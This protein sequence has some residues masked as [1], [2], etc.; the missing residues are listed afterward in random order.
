MTTYSDVKLF[1]FLKTLILY[2]IYISYSYHYLEH[3]Y[4]YDEKA[5]AKVR[6]I[7]FCLALFRYVSDYLYYL[8]YTFIHLSFYGVLK[9][10]QCKILDLQKKIR[11]FYLNLNCQ[12]V[13]PT[14]FKF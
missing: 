5:N 3:Y 8:F 7:L 11:V 10:T 2:N 4:F 6:P 14:K 12:P 1:K 9:I 13:S